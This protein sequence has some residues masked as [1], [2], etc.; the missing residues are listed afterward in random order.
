MTRQ[1]FSEHHRRAL[2]DPLHW[3]GSVPPDAY[4]PLL[5][6]AFARAPSADV[7]ARISYAEST[8]YMHDVLLRDTDQM[9][10]A[11]ALEVRVP[12]LDHRLV[13]FVLA[14]PSRLKLGLE[15]PK[16]LLAESLPVPLP[17]DIVRARKKGFVLPFDEWM[18]GAL[19]PFC[20][21]QLGPA[22][23]DGRGLF[24]PGQLSRLWSGFL[25]RESG[26]GWAR[27]WSLVA[28]NAWMDRHHIQVPHEVLPEARQG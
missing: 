18:R 27:L 19:R 4:E 9:S 13:E 15:Y 6:A 11:H 1:L 25:R 8:A 16:A 20:E 22:G 7:A 2:V 26:V 5:E 23:L 17:A 12:L 28:L 21:T 14:Q 24:R 10:M 3:P